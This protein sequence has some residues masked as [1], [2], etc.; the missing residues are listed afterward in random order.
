MVLN[1]LNSANSKRTYTRRLRRNIIR[2]PI[3]A[4]N[5]V[6]NPRRDLPEYRRRE[7]EPKRIQP[8]ILHT[9]LGHSPVRRHEI[10][11]L[12]SPQG[13][14][15]LI[16]PLITHDTDCFHRE[17]YGKCL[18]DLLVEPCGTDFLYV[19]V[20]RLLEDLYLLERHRT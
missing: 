10:L 11:R 13:N 3:H 8:Y 16:R 15:L 2:D 18:R 4:S 19:D 7:S 17:E 9:I 12:H 20:V 1:K 6:G 14:N 5:F